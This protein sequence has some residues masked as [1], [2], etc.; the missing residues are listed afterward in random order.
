M[1]LYS[2]QRR[3]LRRRQSQNEESATKAKELLGGVLGELEKFNRL[4]ESEEHKIDDQDSINSSE[5]VERM[6]RGL[7]E[8]R[9]RRSQPPNHCFASPFRC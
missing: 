4:I 7:L 2:T 6:E 1:K 8:P 9:N 5:Q 3:R